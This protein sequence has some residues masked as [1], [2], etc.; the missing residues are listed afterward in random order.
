MYVRVHALVY[1]HKSLG[2]P[3]H[4]ERHWRLSATTSSRVSLI[5]EPFSVF[6]SSFFSSSSFIRDVSNRSTCSRSFLYFNNICARNGRGKRR[7]NGR[8]NFNGHYLS[9][10]NTHSNG[11]RFFL[12]SSFHC[13]HSFST[14]LAFPCACSA[15]FFAGGARLLGFLRV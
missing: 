2:T 13:F 15:C 8:R 6:N 1:E 14:A 10:H 5:S 11:Y 12:S 4:K 7:E 9:N 3:F